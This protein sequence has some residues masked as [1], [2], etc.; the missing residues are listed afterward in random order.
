[1][2]RPS[3]ESAQK[4]EDRHSGRTP[5]VGLLRVLRIVAGFLLLGIGLALLVLPG[6][7]WLVIA[8]GLGLLARE[9]QW[10]RALLDKVK[11]KATE[12]GARVRQRA[13][14]E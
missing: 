3:I 4:H 9:F 12:I 13:R 14:R 10:A 2:A 7:G 11:Q 5:A 1:M 6:P 8:L